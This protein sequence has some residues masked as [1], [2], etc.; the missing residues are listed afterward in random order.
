[1]PV[2][3]SLMDR[4]QVMKGAL[5]FGGSVLWPGKGQVSASNGSVTL[6]PNQIA[7]LADTHIGEN[8]G[9]FVY[10]TRWPGSPYQDDDH[11]GVNMAACLRHVI[12][13]IIAQN[14]CPAHVVINGDCAYSNGRVGEYKEFA[15]M[16]EPLYAAGITVHVTIGNH[17]NRTRLWDVIPQLKQEAL[18][19]QTTVVELPK[20][21][22]MLLDS[23]AG[24]FAP[25]QLDWLN[26]QLDLRP[27]KPALVF[28]H[29]NPLPHQGVRP[30]KGMRDGEGQALLEL[31]GRHKHAKAF[32]HGHTHKWKL[33]QWH[34]IHVINQ[35]AVGYYFGKGHA[36]GWV[37][38][39]LT[40]TGAS[41]QLRCV[42]GKHTEHE[43]QRKLVW[44]SV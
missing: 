4:R 12:D 6:D 42:N 36:H 11:E 22:L 3:V 40:D 43:K 13:D 9:Q 10:G 21:N 8:L 32:F 18:G 44:S 28:A 23:G 38:M 19:V 14:P 7:L 33:S 1:M 17:D 27:D 41:L 16:I 34:Q 39:K 25:G 5:V 37:S 20:A 35:P 29:F 15:R 24:K 30:L 2:S 31:M 26:Q